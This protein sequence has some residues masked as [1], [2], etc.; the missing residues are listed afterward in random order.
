MTKSERLMYLVNMIRNKGTVLVREMAVECGVS[1][2]TI[3][4]DVKSLM[5]LNFPL[6]YDNGYRLARDI[7]F[8]FPGLD[9]EDVE[10]ICYSFRNNP[11]SN[12]PFFT[13]KFRV[14]EQDILARCRR[15]QGFGSGNLFL[16]EKDHD[17]VEKTQESDIIA[18]FLRAIRDH[19]KI[20]L[21]LVNNDNGNVV[22]IPLAIRLKQSGLSLVVVN[23]EKL[24]L[25][26]PICNIDSVK[27]T[28]EIFTRRPLNLLRQ[29]PA[30]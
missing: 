15:S 27:L 14:I 8:P 16:F 4:R 28:D 9:S 29:E 12:H 26:Q 25:E 20:T 1:Q 6:Y 5:K 17:P 10:L 13:Q 11:L 3:Y 30:M 22:Y 2:R 19:R 24:L 18:L 21:T 7:S 23:D